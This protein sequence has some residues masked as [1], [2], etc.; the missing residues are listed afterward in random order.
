[1]DRRKKF[2][3][4]NVIRV[5]SEILSYANRSFLFTAKFTLGE[6]SNTHLTH[7]AGYMFV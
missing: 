6:L 2:Q 3:R 4:D 7:R 1:M 5:D